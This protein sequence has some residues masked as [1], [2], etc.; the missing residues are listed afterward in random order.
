MN[1]EKVEK[2]IS[3]MAILIVVVI[4][5]GGLVE[6]VPLMA[7]SAATEPLEG[8]RPYPA[9]QL[10]A[11]TS[12]YAKAA[13]SAIRSR[14]VLSAVRR[15]ATDRIRWPASLFTIDHSS[16]ARSVLGR[17]SRALVNAIATNGIAFIL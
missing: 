9:L 2:N 4:S 8:I 17:T 14:S 1:H 3:L 15:S 11:A 16:S 10:A 6:I 12:T 13:T 7:S 5:I